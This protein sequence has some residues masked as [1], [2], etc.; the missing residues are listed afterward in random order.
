MAITRQL[1][2]K[3]KWLKLKDDVGRLERLSSVAWMQP[4]L[5]ERGLIILLTSTR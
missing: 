3:W 2:P 1:F 4:W 5:A